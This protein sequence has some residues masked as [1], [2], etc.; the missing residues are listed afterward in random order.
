MEA[1]GTTGTPHAILASF[2]VVKAMAET[3]LALIRRAIT[4]PL[5]S[6]SHNLLVAI[7]AH[8]ALPRPAGKGSE[9]RT[10]FG[11][12]PMT[13][14]LQRI[15]ISHY[16]L[17]LHLGGAF[18]TAPRQDFLLLPLSHLTRSLPPY[19]VTHTTLGA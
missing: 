10:R 17:P 11:V 8:L 9:V 2:L 15:E 4:F 7:R 5:F 12:L 14:K 19:A 18:A 13:A 3:L 6:F 1:R 16:V